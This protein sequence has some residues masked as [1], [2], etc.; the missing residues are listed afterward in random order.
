M[1][2]VIGVD[3]LSVSFNGTRALA[4]VS[5]AIER[6]SWVCL[7]GPNGAGKTTLLRAIAGLVPHSG[8]I[9]LDGTPIAQLHRR[10]LSRLVAVVP[11]NPVIPLGMKVVDYVLMGRTPYISY[12]GMESTGDTRIAASVL[13]QLELVPFATRPLA[14]LSGGELQRVILGKALAQQ[15]SILLLDEPTSA[16]DVGHQ[17]QVLELVED[18]RRAH[19]LTVV[20]AMH[21]LTLAGQF[22]DHLILF[23]SGRVVSAGGAREVLTE[24]AIG[25]H[26]GASVRVQGEPDGTVVVIPQRTARDDAIVEEEH[27]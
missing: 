11:Q 22:A 16:L 14:S 2:D 12:L 15:A 19:G 7:I 27:S 18:L 1:T 23:D 4:G 25:R 5:V 8:M 26:Y 10:Q 13:D 20:S 17:Q 3:D 6:G 21:D 24:E 9:R